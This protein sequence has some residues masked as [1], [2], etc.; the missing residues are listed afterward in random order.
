MA[1]ASEN[2]VDGNNQ[3]NGDK[4]YYLKN[5][6]KGEVTRVLI[7][8][9][10]ITRHGA[11]PDIGWFNDCGMAATSAERDYVHVLFKRMKESGYNPCFL[12]SQAADF[13][14][15]F[16]EP[17]AFD[18][19][20]AEPTFNADIIIL[21]LGDNVH[22]GVNDCR[23]MPAFENLINACAKKGVRIIVTGSYFINEKIE[24]LLKELCNKNRYEFVELFDISLNAAN[25]GGKD[26]FW[27]D[28]VALHPGDGGMKIIAERLFDAI[29]K[30]K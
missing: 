7:F 15:N 3:I 28:G 1:K 25:Q 2:S 20:S 24:P 17:C 11:K 9:N 19:L 12:V 5:G 4:I 30:F 8:G 23:L 13:E 18:F 10:S 27:H 22:S 21:R 14:M 29:K 16:Y 6:E 26:K